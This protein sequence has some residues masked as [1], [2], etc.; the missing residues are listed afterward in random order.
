MNL[1]RKASFQQTVIHLLY[2]YIS[3]A[4]QYGAL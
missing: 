1:I 2:S 3:N 4:K